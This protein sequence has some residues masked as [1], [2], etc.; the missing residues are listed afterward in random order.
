MAEPGDTLVTT[1]DAKVQE[2]AQ[3]ALVEGINLA[4]GAHEWNA[5][6][7]AAVALDV[8]NGDILAM[9]SYPTFDPSVWVGGISPKK[10]KSIFNRKG[11]NYPA[12]NRAIQET[13]AVGSTFKPITAVAALEEGVISSGM[14]VW[15]P[16]YYESSYDIA[17]KKTKFGCWAPERAREPRP[18]RRAHAVVR[19]LLLPRRRPVLRAQGHGARGLGEAARHGQTDRHRHPRRIRWARP[20]A[21]VEAR[22]LPDRDRRAVEAE[23]LDLPRHRAGQPRGHAAPAGDAYAAIAN[24]G[25]IVQPHSASRS[26]TPTGKTVRSLDAGRA[27]AKLDI[28]RRRSTPCA[29]ASRGRAQ[30]GRHVGADLR[31]YQVAVAGKTG[32]AEV[33]DSA[34][35]AGRLRLV[36]ELRAGQR[37]QV[38]GRGHDREGRPRRHGRRAGRAHDLRRALPHRQRRIFT[39]RRSRSD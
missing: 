10:Y 34:R 13:K 15:C 29:T 39:R 4:H 33:W 26:S 12:I 31:G 25:K 16:G 19:H 6:G 28:S 37:S 27:G 5:N 22:A 35:T 3:Q 21:G 30:R 14:T 17:A 24:G 36:R 11:T 2:A 38:R 8:R 1:I 20:D 32:T 9:A 23:R 18:D 7:G